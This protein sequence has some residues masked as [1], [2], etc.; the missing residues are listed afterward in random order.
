[1]EGAKARSGVSARPRRPLA[2][3]AAGAL[4]PYLCIMYVLVLPAGAAQLTPAFFVLGSYS[5]PI[6]TTEL[7][8][9]AVGRGRW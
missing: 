9:C 5:G 4:V 3:P 7:V 2:A 8:E 6:R 1:M